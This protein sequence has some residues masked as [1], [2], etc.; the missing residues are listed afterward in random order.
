MG[1]PSR[2]ARARRASHSFVSAGQSA[3]RASAAAAGGA[4]RTVHRLTG[5]SGA[6]TTGLSH[7]IELTAAG[8]VG[9]AF[10]AV[11]LAGTLF[12]NTS[13][14]QARSQ[15]ALY[16]LITMA[17]FAVLAPF[18]GPVLDR[19]QQ[20]RRFILAGTLLARGLLCW[21]MSAALHQDPVTLFPA[22]F[23]VLI[24]QKVY[25]VTRAAVA[26]RLLPPQLTLVSANARMTL[27]SLIASTLG[28]VLAAGIEYTSSAAWVLRL[29]ALVYIAGTVIGVRLPGSVDAGEPRARPA[30]AGAPDS[31]GPAGPGGRAGAGSS[32]DTIPGPRNAAG[33]GAPRPGYADPRYAGPG[34]ADPRYGGPGYAE[35]GYGDP[36]YGDPGYGDPGY[37][38][39]GRPAGPPGYPASENGYPD[40]AHDYRQGAGP[41][42]PG[43]PGGRPMM[44]PGDPGSQGP[45]GS[46]GSPGSQGRAGAPG[47]PGR[48]GPADGNGFQARDGSTRPLPGKN[49]GGLRPLRL[50]GPVVGEAMRGNAALRAFSGFMLLFLAFLLR[51][52]HF[53]GLPHNAA[54]GALAAA[55]AAGGFLGTAVGSKLKAKRP[56][57]IV[58]GM[59]GTAMLVSAIGAWFFGLWTAL[60]V[61]FVAATAQALVKLALDST[62][63]REVGE[64]IRSSTFAV[65]ETLNQLSWVIGGLAGL[66]LSL[67]SSGV[68]GLS[69]A[70]AG[71]AAT[72]GLL[73]AGRR[74]RAL[75]AQRRRAAPQPH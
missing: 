55:V 7:L 3:A 10:V 72:L 38:G 35:S 64:E 51:A 53:R 21:G 6:G 9:D 19:V 62:V 39:R 67:T 16:L 50:V 8:S 18:I 4:G 33:P 22:A 24:L 36:R 17:P 5:A 71:L 73:V 48:G 65:S 66:A 42:Y 44:P 47:P 60:A 46:P 13:L 70:A 14:T 59:L 61:A 74:N 45:P 28:V 20:G 11:S 69:V 15:V 41:G 30:G 23:G 32:A 75:A 43:A 25:T 29:G 68:A 49:R 52:D 57:L 58:F 56:H 26:P 63:Q 54:L 31:A 37:P 40:P 34:Y 27:A 2:G 1:A 12:F